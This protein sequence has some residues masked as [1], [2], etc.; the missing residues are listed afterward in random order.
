MGKARIIY[1]TGMK[2][3]PDPAL[4]RVEL[5]RV[6]G[7]SLGR[8]APEA[9]EWLAARPENFTLVSWTSLLYT[10]PRDLALD[11]PGVERLL[12]HPYPTAEDKRAAD[13]VG[14]QLRRGW[15]LIGDS[16]PSLSGLLASPALKVTLADVHGYLENRNHLAE[17]VRQLLIDALEAAWA[18]GDRVLLIGHSLGSVIAYDTL[19]HLS[20]QTDSDGRVELLLTLGSPLATRFI[21]KGLLGADRSGAERYPANIDRWV[22][23]SARGEMVALHRRVKPFFGGMLKFGLVQDIEDR[24]GIYNHFSGDYGLDVHKSYGYLNHPVV[25]DSICRWLGYSS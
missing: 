18:D 25:A 4:H 22:N 23:I 10:E 24:P 2:A 6:L 13:A 1:I 15:H 14:L 20:R 19:W 7:A 8:I 12:Q 3:K 11:L 9:R 21:R 17:R 16:F 5:M